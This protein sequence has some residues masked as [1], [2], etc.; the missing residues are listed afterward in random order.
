MLVG[1][2]LFE[3]LELTLQQARGH[4]MLVARRDAACTHLFVALEIDETYVVAISNEHV[5]VAPLQG[6]TGDDA[7]PAGAT[8]LVYPRRNGAQP[9]PAILVVERHAAVHLLDIGGR[10]EPVGILEFPA[11]A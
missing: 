8:L 5:A 10:M 2:R 4:E 11:E 9:R 6:G 7:M 1:N 3:R